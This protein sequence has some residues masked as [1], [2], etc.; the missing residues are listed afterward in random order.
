MTLITVEGE[1]VRASSWFRRLRVGESILL[2]LSPRAA[3]R[4][5]RRLELG[6]RP[7]LV[8]HGTGELA[9]RRALDVP[10]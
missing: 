5:F 9:L 8:E 1:T 6:P 10:A 4:A 7:L 3:P 2:T